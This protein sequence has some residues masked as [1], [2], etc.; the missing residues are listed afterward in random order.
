MNELQV[1]ENPEFGEIRV[2]E[3]DGEPWFVAADVCRALDIANTTIALERLD[4]DERSKFNL[5]RQGDTWCVNEP[6]LYSLV[7]GSRK[8]EAKTFKRWITHEVIPSIRKHG[9]YMTP[10]TIEQAILSPDFIIRLAQKLKDEME[11][12]KQAEHDRQLMAIHCAHQ[13]PK[14]DYFDALVDANMLTTFRETAKLLHVSEKRFIQFL[15]TNRYL[16]RAR[17]GRLLP[18]ATVRSERVLDVKEV[19][20]P[21]NNWRGLQTFVT[22]RGRETF[23]LLLA[24]KPESRMWMLDQ[25]SMPEEMTEEEQDQVEAYYRDKFGEEVFPGF[26]RRRR[27]K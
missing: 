24:G 8:P 22:P 23:R 20:D 1:F 11:L 4:E 15:L 3:R 26:R 9:A 18:Y 14:I 16:F 5:G 7:L 25:Y 19:H 12:R 17:N 21:K 27:A 6:G 13:Q 2:V 10:E